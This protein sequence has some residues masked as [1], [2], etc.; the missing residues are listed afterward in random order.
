MK[1]ANSSENNSAINL[2]IG[3][4]DPIPRNH[5][6]TFTEHKLALHTCTT[7]HTI[8]ARGKLESLNCCHCQA[9]KSLK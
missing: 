2:I 6:S 4:K 1:P 5:Y 7:Y 3:T 8:F 9:S